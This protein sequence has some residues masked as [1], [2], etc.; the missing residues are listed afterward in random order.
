VTTIAI[1]GD[2]PAGLSAALFLARAGHETIV[3][4]TDETAMHYAMLH[5][6][7]GIEEMLGSDFQKVARQQVTAAGAE[8]RNVEVTRIERDGDGRFI[9]RTEDGELTAD[10]VVL[11][12]GKKAKDL[13]VGLDVTVEDGRVPVD[14]EY[15]T[16]VDRVY[17]VGR[18]VR[19]ERSQAIISAG[20]GA[21]VALDILS[22]EAGRD[23]HD[24]DSPPET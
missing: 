5:N 20:A 12:G 10:H 24:W 15:R 16:N 23:V 4:G 22:R 11:A 8:L 9:V 7:L 17:A 2:G 3:L 1:I 14:T 21:T 6:Y 18:L 19:P 13:A